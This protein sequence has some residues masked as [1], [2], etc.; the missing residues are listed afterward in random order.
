ME[1]GVIFPFRL[2]LW[3][4]GGPQRRV[5]Y[6]DEETNLSL[7]RFKL[8][9][10]SNKA[11]ISVTYLGSSNFASRSFTFTSIRF[12]RFIFRTKLSLKYLFM[13][14]ELRSSLRHHTFNRQWK[15]K[16]FYLLVYKAVQSI[17]VSRRF[18][19]TCRPHFQGRKINQGRNSMKQVEPPRNV[20]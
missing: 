13:I 11:I 6:G 19:G 7:A 3:R 9:F 4:L 18:G 16:K 15:V 17:E 2:L 10:S 20:G 8:Q 5:A 1:V 12:T 14:R